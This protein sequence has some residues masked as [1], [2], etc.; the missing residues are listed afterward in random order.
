MIYFDSDV[1]HKPS[2]PTKN[3]RVIINFIFEKNK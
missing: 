1:T 3:E 2:L